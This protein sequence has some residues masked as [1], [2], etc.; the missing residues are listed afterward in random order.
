MEPNTA[1]ASGSLA[2]MRLGS[3]Y[4]NHDSDGASLSP[5]KPGSRTEPACELPG[6][7]ENEEAG[8]QAAGVSW[9]VC[10]PPV[11]V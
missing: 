11:V 10:M 1:T 2:L 7:Q 6:G 8:L 4:R 9:A 5:S 3:G